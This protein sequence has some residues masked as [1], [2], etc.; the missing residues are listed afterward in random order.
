MLHLV[1]DV[2]ITSPLQQSQGGRGDIEL[3]HLVLLNHIPVAREV[4]VGWSTLEDDGCAT[5]QQGS[6]YD[7]GVTSD[8]ADITTAEVAVVIMDIKD[9]FSTDSSTQKVTG[10][11][12]HDTLGLAGRTRGIEEEEG[13]FGVHGLWGDVGRVLFNLLVPPN[14]AALCPGNLG[15]GAFVDKN[16]RYIRA[17]LQTLVDDALSPDDLT[18]TL[19]FVCRDD[20]LGASVDDTVTQRVGGETGENDRVD[21]TDTRASKESDESLG[22][23]GKIDGHC[24]ALLD[25]ALLQDPRNSGDLAEKLTVCDCSTLV[26]FVGLVDNGNLVGVLDGVSV[27]AVVRS[28]QLTLDEPSIVSVLQ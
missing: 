7:V 1:M 3:G 8:P 2:L 17:L 9:I 22:N 23:H 4:R 26:G 12:V 6:V 21:S 27:D 15:T 25:P 20:N 14:V 13:V 24:V 18:T 19:S 16:R 10:S 28:I 5:Q 11:G